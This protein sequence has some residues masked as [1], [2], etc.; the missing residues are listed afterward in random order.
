MSA[1]D[2]IALILV[3]AAAT[4][5]GRAMWRTLAGRGGCSCG[6]DG[7]CGRAERDSSARL[8]KRVSVVTIEQVGRPALRR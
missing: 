3:L 5:V 6:Q 1:Q 4:F 8:G 7:T 2:G